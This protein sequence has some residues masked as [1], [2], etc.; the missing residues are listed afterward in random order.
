MA[1]TTIVS[2]QSQADATRYNNSR[3]SFLA[4]G[5]Y[6]QFFTDGTNICFSSSTTYSTWL[7]KTSVRACVNGASFSTWYDPL[8]NY[9]H[10]AYAVNTANTA[11]YYN[12]GVPKADGTISWGAEVTVIA[13]A[14]SVYMWYP[15]VTV[16]TYGYPYIQYERYDGTNTYPWV[17]RS[18]TNDGTWT[19][20]ASFPFQLYNVSAA[21]YCN[22]LP[23]KTGKM[24]C[25]FDAGSVIRGRTY[26]GVSTWNAIA[27]TASTN[28]ALDFSPLTV[29]DVCYMVYISDPNYDIAFT[30]F[31][32]TGN[33]WTADVQVQAA[34]IVTCGVELCWVSSFGDLTLYCFW[35][36]SP[37]VGHVYYKRYINGI[38]DA[39][40]TDWVTDPT[41]TD[42]RYIGCFIQ[43]Y[44]KGI[45][46]GWI[47]NNAV[48]G[49]DIRFNI[50]TLQTPFWAKLT[51]NKSLLPWKERRRW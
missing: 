47:K 42:N 20:P 41:F 31:S 7:A 44:G 34:T 10:Y 21:E 9:V 49:V 32:Y 25:I 11:L 48:S 12:R 43:S 50:F 22:V 2:G 26:D 30:T 17:T 29:G 45:G 33:A 19:T 51:P 4:K 1:P 23:M 14:A 36:S 46:V 5:R 13:A 27:A 16:D 28:G 18:S 8:R 3:K 40:P 38:W 6:W 24:M 39:S 37:T 15:S 35:L